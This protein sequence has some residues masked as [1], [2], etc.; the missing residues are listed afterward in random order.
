MNAVTRREAIR[1]LAMGLVAAPA[2]LR[3]RFRLF[4]QS[5]AQYSA[6]AVRL[7]ESSIVVDLLNQFQFPDFSVRPPK[8]QQWLSQPGTFTAE[9]AARYQGSGITSFALG[10]GAGSYEDAVLFHARWNGFLA[11]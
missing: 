9:D 4:A 8:I 3:G 10:A 5:N 6:R 1:A 7:V 11:G 2:A